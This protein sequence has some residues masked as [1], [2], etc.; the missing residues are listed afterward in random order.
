[1]HDR[2]SRFRED[3]ELS[4]LNADPR[5]VVPVS[6]TMARLIGAVVEAGEL[7]GGLVDGTLAG[8]IEAAGYRSDLG[9]PVPLPLAL[10]LA[11][12]RRP[13]GAANGWGGMRLRGGL[14]TRPPS[15]Q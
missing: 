12:A 8:E 3:S 7:T 10:R 4:R 13:A 9:A 6:E 14:H 1:W 2:F 15:L 5:A 11:P